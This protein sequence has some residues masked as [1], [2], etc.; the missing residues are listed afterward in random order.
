MN[1][2]NYTYV[3]PTYEP[4]SDI[5][6]PPPNNT[7]ITKE[8][9]L[10]KFDS[11]IRKHEINPCN[12]IRLRQLEGFEIVIICD[13]SGS[14][15]NPV[16]NPSI[17]NHNNLPSRWDELKSVVSTVIEIAGVLDKT[18]VDIYF[19]NRPGIKNVTD[20][21]QIE[22]YFATEPSGYTPIVSVFNQVLTE[23]QNVLSE[24]KLLIL[25]ATDG[26]PT[27]ENGQVT[28]NGISEKTRFFNL[29]KSRNP[30]D[31]IYT[32]ILAC[33]DDD[34]VMNYLQ[35]W[36]E[37]IKNLDV[38]DDFHTVKNNVAKKQG[39]S[40]HFTF[41]DYIVKI[42]LGSMDTFFDEI[43]EVKETS[44]GCCIS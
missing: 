41:G 34:D 37:N 22:P 16:S 7:N 13:D 20:V 6:I 19:L 23:M 5:Q 21:S 31:K 39:M 15:S 33:T 36:D 14:M 42:L 24:K 9:R 12:A 43:D 30:I 4:P 38:V 18:G 26:E 25:L 2:Y 10:A 17:T 11:I 40:Y 35:D 28:T 27:T 8:N 1:N 44:F 29:L 3:Y 32:T